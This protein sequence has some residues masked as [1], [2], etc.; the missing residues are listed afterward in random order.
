MDEKTERF[1][2]TK[3]QITDMQW[4]QN[5]NPDIFKDELL[6]HYILLLY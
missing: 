4:R 2:K 3:L 1:H 5:S 6:I